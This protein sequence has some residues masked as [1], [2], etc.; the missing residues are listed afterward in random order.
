MKPNPELSQPGTLAFKLETCP[1]CG[2]Y[3]V[4]TLAFVSIPQS[5]HTDQQP[6]LA[7]DCRACA[8]GRC[9]Y[10]GSINRTQAHKLPSQTHD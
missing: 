9:S 3:A 1:R 6:N 7:E 5:Q 4:D 10:D 2:A 8:Y